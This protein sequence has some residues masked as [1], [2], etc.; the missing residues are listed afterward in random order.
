MSD[1]MSD[2]MKF[3]VYIFPDGRVVTE[4]EDRGR[5]LCTEIYKVTSA[6]GT[7]RSDEHIGPEGDTVHEI[8]GEG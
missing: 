6:V 3:D 7:Q 8:S 1:P 4:V 5:H 2:P